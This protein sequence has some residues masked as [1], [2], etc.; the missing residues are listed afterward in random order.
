[1]KWLFKFGYFRED[2]KAGV[3]YML[4]SSFTLSLFSLFGKFAT[5]STPFL[6]LTFLRFVIPLAIMLPFFLWKSTLKEL[7]ATSHLKLQMLRALCMIVYQYSIFYYLIRATLL[8]ATVLQNT[9]PLFLPILERIF[10][11]RHF[12]RREIISIAICFLGVLC[13][14]QPDMGILENLGIVVLLTPMSQAASQLLFAH[15]ARRENHKSNLFYL[16]FFCSI[17]SGI[18]LLCVPDFTPKTAVS[19]HSLVLAWGSVV[20]LGIMS[21]FNQYFRGKAY[22]SCRPSSL[23]PFLYFSVIVSAFLDWMIFGDLPNFLSAVGALFVISGGLIQLWK[24]KT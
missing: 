2:L 16:Y 5:E 22:E 8:D 10:F 7:F 6:L 17:A 24:R 23:A 4:L 12:D 18:I 11:N 1:M 9:F 13:I 14:L 20:C 15:Q 3:S 19:N 21:I